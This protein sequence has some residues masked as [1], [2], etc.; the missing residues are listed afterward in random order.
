MQ[1]CGSDRAADVVGTGGATLSIG[2]A[3]PFLTVFCGKGGTGGISDETLSFLLEPSSD[4]L[5]IMVGAC[6][7]SVEKS[8]LDRSDDS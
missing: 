4:T 1:A 5:R 7:S 8:E 2:L 6:G 3:A